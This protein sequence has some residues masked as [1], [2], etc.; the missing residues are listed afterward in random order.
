VVSKKTGGGVRGGV[1]GGSSRLVSIVVTTP[2]LGLKVYEDSS[3]TV[4][5]E[6]GRW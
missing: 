6:V 4:V 1:D 5:E 3:S 2:K